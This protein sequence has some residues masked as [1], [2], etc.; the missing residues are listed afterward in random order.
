MTVLKHQA[1]SIFVGFKALT[2]L[3]HQACHQVRFPEGSQISFSPVHE[4]TKTFDYYIH[5]MKNTCLVEPSAGVNMF[6]ILQ[7]LVNLCINKTTEAVATFA[8]SKQITK[9]F[10]QLIQH[11]TYLIRTLFHICNI[12]VSHIKLAINQ[13]HLIIISHF[14]WDQITPHKT[15]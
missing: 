3:K 6:I 9:H 15:I 7:L 14:N 5:L 12:K 10:T 13:Y 1:L 11:S 2:M 4:H 8:V